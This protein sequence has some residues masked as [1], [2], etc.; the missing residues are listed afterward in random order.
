MKNLTLI[1]IA[2]HFRVSD[3]A[4]ATTPATRL[5]NILHNMYH[6]RPLT[7]LS[8]KFLQE[9][10]FNGLHRLAT[11]QINYETFV[12]TAGPEMQARVQAAEIERQAAETERQTKVAEQ[13]AR[14]AE[15]AAKYK[16]EC[17]AAELARKARE[18]DPKYI[19]KVKNQ[20]LRR[21][22]GMDFI[23]EPLFA[24]MMNILKCIDSGSRLTDDDYVWLST[25]AQGHFTKE[26]EA[27]Y[28]LRE[29]EF[30]ADKYHDTK[31]PWNAIT[32]SSNYR[33][34]DHAGAA[35]DLLDRV[36]VQRL[37]DPKAKAAICT[38]RGGAMR[39]MG[40]LEAAR[41]LGEQ[42]HALQPQDY[43]P[44]TLLGAVHM[45]LGNFGEARDWY[46]KA[47][48]RGASERTI[49]SDLRSILLR[50]DKTKREAIKS[51]LLK[52]DANRYHRVREKR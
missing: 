12:A 26:L 49:D 35:L 51:F 19:A 1:D 29:A 8:V 15:W 2:R 42:G 39:D 27:A 43:R 52:E 6:G 20:E 11:S 30:F 34:C 21:R 33:K 44:C 40:L 46:A 47:E 3:I 36:P 14:E 16:R 41:Q 45:E 10:N 38:T 37:K 22:Y 17:E 18:S 50:A 4:S 25:T 24:R 9:K 7:A 32:A 48:E 23:D 28:Y 5:S 31:D 13:M